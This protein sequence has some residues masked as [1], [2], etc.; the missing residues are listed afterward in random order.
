MA[1]KARRRTLAGALVLLIASAGA[2][3]LAVDFF[4][5]LHSPLREGP[6]ESV[7][8]TVER[9]M[10]VARIARKLG[11]RGLID[12][13][14]YLRLAARFTGDAR[15]IQSGEYAI[16]TGTTPYRLLAKFARGEVKTYKITL[17]EG[18]TFDQM[19]VA[20][21]EHS[22]LEHT[23]KDLAPEAIMARLGHPDQHPEGR[24][25]PDTYQFRRGTTDLKLLERAYERMQT[26]LTE[27]WAGRSE[28]LPLDTPYEALTLASI[29]ERETAV[30]EE[31]ARIAGVFLERLERGM[32][33]QTDPTVIYGLGDDF[34][35]DLRWRDLRTDTP[36][37]TYTRAGLPPTPI[38][39][40]ARASIHASLHP[41]RRGEL[42]F[43]SRGDGTHV[44]SKTYEAHK[45][46]VAKYQL[47]RDPSKVPDQGVSEDATDD[48]AQAGD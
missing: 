10:P 3:V 5:F 43:V 28:D 24:F 18:W 27:E 12:R 15:R 44:F 17:I 23:L 42:Y 8:F 45:Q 26:V 46:A 31:R 32:R 39:M 40:P 30:A 29:V 37:N 41:E 47:G 7:T 22:A 13:P 1:R 11:E 36:Y 48:G 35:G 21:H 34:D 33:L 2:G 20:I 25:F 16:D 9:G 14:L 38:A 19:M 4:R 6:S